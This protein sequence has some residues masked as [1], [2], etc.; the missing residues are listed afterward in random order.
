MDPKKGSRAGKLPIG[1]HFSS[2]EPLR[3]VA[4]SRFA[5]YVVVLPWIRRRDPVLNVSPQRIT[6]HKIS[7][8]PVSGF[9]DKK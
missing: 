5:S 9:N 6:Y 1:E 8:F 7:G 2:N 4:I 3:S